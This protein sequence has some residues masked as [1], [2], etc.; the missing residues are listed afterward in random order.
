MLTGNI[1]AGYFQQLCVHLENNFLGQD[2]KM[3][4]FLI[5]SENA[6]WHMGGVDLFRDC[7]CTHNTF[8]VHRLLG[9]LLQPVPGAEQRRG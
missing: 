6:P 8:K 1:D 5:I 9:R 3:E 2:S 4:I 7:D